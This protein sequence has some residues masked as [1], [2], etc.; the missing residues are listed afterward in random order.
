MC[1]VNPASGSRRSVE[2]APDAEAL[3]RRAAELFAALASEAAARSGR[4]TVALAGGSTPRRLYE[5]LAEEGGTLP[6]RRVHIFWG[7]E[8]LV[9]PDDPESNYRMARESLL[10]RIT[11]PEENVH[12][13]PVGRSADAGR[14]S[15]EYEGTLRAFFEAEPG[16]VPRLDLVLLGMGADGHTA[17]L[18]PRS[19]AL[20]ERSRL[21]AAV[22]A[23]P[24]R[25]ARVTMTVPF[26][27]SASHVVFLV[28]GRGK[29]EVLRKVLEGDRDPERL[30]AQLIEPDDGDLVWLV[31]E[32]A[33]ALLERR[34]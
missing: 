17:S 10:D 1:P 23:H 21:I 26:L 32:E 15:E 14:A 13:V 24:P 6:W 4:F 7:D 25:T 20:H 5:L 33:A 9:P 27:R 34:E 8:R 12:R 11:I 22:P 28:S 29:A 19:A 30:P 18:F 16:R 3:A 2:V 31:D